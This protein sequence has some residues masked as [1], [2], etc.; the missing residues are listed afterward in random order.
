[1]NPYKEI[2]V[3]GDQIK[4]PYHQFTRACQYSA[5]LQDPQA[6]PLRIP[7]RD[8]AAKNF[9]PDTITTFFEVFDDTVGKWNPREPLDC[10]TLVK[11]CHVFWWLKCDTRALR[12][13][14]AVQGLRDRIQTDSW[15]S[16][17]PWCAHRLVISLVLCWKEQLT[18]SA[19]NWCINQQP[20]RI[21]YRG[22]AKRDW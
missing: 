19:M 1:M 16:D 5:V 2:I 9:D 20:T 8:S 17:K 4:V 22:T 6:E 7:A 21:I 11:L 15:K 13:S 18:A 12:L 10:D 14:P 3:D